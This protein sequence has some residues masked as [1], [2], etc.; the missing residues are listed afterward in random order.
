VEKYSQNI[1]RTSKKL[2][3]YR[4]VVTNR[5]K[6]QLRIGQSGPI[7][8]GGDGPKSSLKEQRIEEQKPEIIS[9]EEDSMK[10]KSSSKKNHSKRKKKEIIR[11]VNKI[12][13]FNL[14]VEDNKVS[15]RPWYY[16]LE[17][18]WWWGMTEDQART[19]LIEVEQAF[20]KNSK[21]AIASIVRNEASNGTLKRFLSCCHKLEK[22]HKNIIYI[23]IEG[24]SSD[25]TY[26]TL[27]NWLTPKKN[28][29]L[30]KIDRN[31]RPF[32]KDRNPKRTIY[33]AE[34]RN[35]LIDLVLSIPE[36]SEVLMIDANYGWKSD[37]ISSLRGA[38][39]DIAAPLVVMHKDQHGKYLFY[40][41]WAFR[42]NGV[43]FS[44]WHPY[45]KGLGQDP[46]DIDSA[47]GGYLVK[48]EVLEAG[49][50]YN[51]DRDCEHVGFC[52]AARDMGF[53]IKINPRVYIRK[54]GHE[55]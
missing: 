33:F 45:T 30:K 50:R 9:E 18:D 29:I 27:Q 7:I 49:V 14:L 5:Q 48:R 2:W 10:K 25:N 31:H 53:T 39:A 15:N 44:H 40:D 46:L 47:G 22:S 23:F 28:Y 37:L 52:Q 54:G 6:G 42:K 4:I 24:D 21:V 55:E 32:A 17:G 1:R 43:Q 16:G 20:E 26:E 41:T 34:L 13:R 12:D 51:G 38:D 19:R 11:S 3:I 35:M 36:V 8:I